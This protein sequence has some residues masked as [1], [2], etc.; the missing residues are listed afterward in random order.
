MRQKRKINMHQFMK[1]D[2]LN[3]DFEDKWLDSFGSPEMSGSWIIWGNP[4]N[5]KTRFAIQLARYLSLFG[6][7]VY[8]SLEEGRSLSLQNAFKSENMLECDGRVFLYDRV[9]YNE[10][11]AFLNKRRSP[12]IIIIDS[13]QYMQINYSQ[14]SRLIEQFPGK[15]FILISHADGRVP[16]GRVAKRIRFDASVKIWVQGYKA[17]PTGRYGGGAPFVIWAEGAE[18][19]WKGQN[20]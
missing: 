2:H 1:N 20:I 3:M 13:L 11:I 16:E 19:F 4:G 12:N 18:R 17:F 7:V 8:D 5:G 10:L 15:L 9:R 6:V 14:Y